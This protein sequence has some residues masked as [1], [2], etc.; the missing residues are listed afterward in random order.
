MI[1]GVILV[2]S[3]TLVF[4]A[5]IPTFAFQAVYFL[6]MIGLFLTHMYN[7]Y[8]LPLVS[9]Q[10][11]RFT[12]PVPCT[13]RNADAYLEVR[14]RTWG[15]TRNTKHGHHTCYYLSPGRTWGYSVHPRFPLGRIISVDFILDAAQRTLPFCFSSLTHPVPLIDLESVSAFL[16]EPWRFTTRQP[17]MQLLRPPPPWPCK[18]P[19]RSRL[20]DTYNGNSVNLRI[21]KSFLAVSLSL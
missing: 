9:I 13:C 20:T 4:F 5:S 10:S 17:A 15:K 18:S 12:C 19:A 6:Q 2:Q 1:I 7:V 14:P 8:Y 11:Y 21:R 3:R 16:L